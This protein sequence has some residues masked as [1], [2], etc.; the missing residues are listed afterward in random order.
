MF[1]ITFQGIL[2]SWVALE[3]DASATSTPGGFIFYSL[4][5]FFEHDS[6]W[7][8]VYLFGAPVPKNIS[9]YEVI[10]LLAEEKFNCSFKFFWKR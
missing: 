5:Q 10:S 6:I 4:E 7:A 8:N 9:F 3:Y 1:V 2:E